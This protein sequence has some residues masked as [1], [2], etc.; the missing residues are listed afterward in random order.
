MGRAKITIEQMQALAKSRGG[1]CLTKKYVNFNTKLEW[2]CS[3]GHRW[4]ASI[5][6]VKY[7]QTWCPEC[8]GSKKLTINE[9]NQIAS[10]CG[11]KCLSKRYI[12]NHTK[13][14]WECAEGH[15]WKTS[16]NS[17]RQGSTWCPVCS[18]KSGGIK[19][20]IGIEA[21]HELAKSRG[22]KCVSNKYTNA[23]TKLE[24]KCAKGHRWKSTPSSVKSGSWCPECAG[25]SKSTIEEMREIAK[26]RGGK[27]LSKKYVNINT[28][29]HWECVEGHRWESAPSNIKFGNWC[30]VCSRKSSGIK[31]RIGIEAMHEL[32]KSRGGKCLSN[33]YVTG[34]DKLE[35]E[36]E[37]GH[38]WKTTPYSVR[39]GAWCRECAGKIKLTISQMRQLA[40]ERGGKCL[41]KKY[42]NNNT[43]L[44]W[45]C[46]EGH[47]WYSKPANIKVGTWCSE[48]DSGV[49]E[50]ICRAY[51]TQLFGKPFP[52]SYPKWLKNSAGNQ[53]ELDGYCSSLRIAF[54][55]QGEQHYSTNTPFVASTKELIKL[56]KDDKKKARLCKDNGV[57]LMIIPEL[58]SRTKLEELQRQIFDECKRLKIHRPAGMLKKKI[59]LKHAWSSN[60]NKQMLN[61]M[62]EIAKARGGKCLSKMYLNAHLNLK[63]LCAKGHEW[64]ASTKKVKFG[65]SWCPCC[66]NETNTIKYMKTIAQDSGG[67]CL[68]KE[69]VNAKT[70]LKWEC[71]KG[72]RWEAISDSI[73]RG[74]WCPECGGN[75]KLT[76][77][78]MR[79]IASSHGGKCLSKKYVN[80]K[81]KLEWECAAGHR[82]KAG[83]V[84]IK[85]GKWCPKCAHKSRGLK[86]RIGIKKMHE[87]AKSH[88][89]KCISTSFINMNT[90]LNWECSAGHQWSAYPNNVK[91]NKSWCPECS[92][93]SRRKTTIK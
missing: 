58:F 81:V 69:Y 85:L 89:G 79:K 16:P 80:Q 82:W 11:G 90:K 74:S 37:Y 9:M 93:A 67:K 27:C 42:V 87:L 8:G 24:W 23:R 26:R 51:C 39:N 10:D 7:L 30:P 88:G 72:H 1:K 35:W 28:K 55:H 17:I 70:K 56:Q 73:K 14:E 77:S 66:F 32:A 63:W 83:S 13:L 60:Q 52:K 61:E 6:N 41:S 86:K 45:E 91:Y 19:R 53:L 44:K 57:R 54:E 71:A 92:Y 4:K 15:R 40:I 62:K 47:Q 36:C 12:N 22:G 46:A 20:R 64:E 21:M 75:K 76:I 43:K 33:E 34:K 5:N 3:E 78:Q 49:S 68:S 18:R 50:R 25:Q 38:R 48:C 84:G 2:E 29:L 65:N 59:S 31:R